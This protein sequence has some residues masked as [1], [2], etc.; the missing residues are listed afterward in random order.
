MS[1]LEEVKTILGDSLQLGERGR[2]FTASTRLLGNLPELDSM[3][4]VS[5]ITALEQHFGFMVNDDEITADT[6]ETLGSLS[7]FVDQKLK[8]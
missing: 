2:V 1:T 7:A 6:F 3:A 4:V 5:V 8:A